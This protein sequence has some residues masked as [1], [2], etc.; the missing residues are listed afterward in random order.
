[1]HLGGIL[2]HVH[3]GNTDTTKARVYISFDAK[4]FVILGD[5]IAFGEVG[6]EIVFTVEFGH[7]GDFAVQGQAYLYT[8]LYRLLVGHGKRTGKAETNGTSIYIWF[9]GAEGI[10]FA[11][12]EHLALG[13]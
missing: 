8:V 13:I 11:A 5:L 6:V 12:A 9:C 3:A 4:G 7:L 1:M 10:V 2:F